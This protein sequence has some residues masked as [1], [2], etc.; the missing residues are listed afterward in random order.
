MSARP[1]IKIP[2]G[3]LLV[4]RSGPGGAALT[5]H[6]GA[7]AA[8][9]RLDRV[10]LAQLA[11]ELVTILTTPCGAAAASSPMHRAVD[12]A[13]ARRAFRERLERVG[14]DGGAL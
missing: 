3:V 5:S 12:D 14:P 7:T 2:G 9:L 13:L 6:T 1:S 11:D 10:A 4:S 8:T